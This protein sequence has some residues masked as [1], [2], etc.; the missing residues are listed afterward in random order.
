V[1]R[2]AV[3][4]VEI[5]PKFHGTVTGYTYGCRCPECKEANRV[6]HAE[7][8]L[9]RNREQVGNVPIEQAREIIRELMKTMT[10]LDIAVASK[11]PRETIFGIM[12]RGKYV[13][14]GTYEKLLNVVDVG[15]SMVDSQWCLK[16]ERALM[17]AGWSQS[18]LAKEIGYARSAASLTRGPWHHAATVK[19]VHVINLLKV[20][21]K[22]RY[23]QG[24]NKETVKYATRKGYLP[25]FE[26]DEQL[27][28]DELFCKLVEFIKL[29]NAA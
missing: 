19:R 6:D 27:Q 28:T 24:P 11:V 21:L 5:D 7:Y 18:W 20:Y 26:I 15:P 4:S 2:K 17:R 1:T 13:Y 10:T 8:I 25:A 22:F 3:D 12:A 23:I 29:K 14:R 16:F 9:R